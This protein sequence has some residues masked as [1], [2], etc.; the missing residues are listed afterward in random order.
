VVLLKGITTGTLVLLLSLVGP[1]M[2]KNWFVSPDGSGD[3][4]TIQAA[5]DSASSGDNIMVEGGIY[6]EEVVVDVK[7]LSI[8]ASGGIPILY[9]PTPGSGSGIVFRDVTGS[10]T[11][12]G[13]TIEGFSK[14]VAIENS[15]P[16]LFGFSFKE[17]NRALEVTG[18]GS[19]PL[20]IDNLVDSCTTGFLVEDGSLVDVQKHTIVNCDD[21][22][23]IS[24][25]T[26]NFE[27]NI[28]A[29]CQTGILVTGGSISLSC[30][31]VWNNDVNYSG[32]SQGATDICED[33]MFC[34]RTPGSLGL[35]YLHQ[36][37]P[38]WAEN[39]A[40]GDDMG[41]YT[42]VVGCTGTATGDCSWGSIKEMFR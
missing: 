41:T 37:S 5:V 3:A 17:C 32:C 9:S 19:S 31:D 36:D 14:G 24:G 34:Y 11:L 20:I 15:S 2:A 25:G 38:C 27:R 40:C 12:M 16:W 39:N 8:K 10:P 33:P 26:V 23:V 28:V 42:Q 6:Y 4:P 29:G 22:F 18:S 7:S 30:N 21:G 35:Y 1:L 13:L